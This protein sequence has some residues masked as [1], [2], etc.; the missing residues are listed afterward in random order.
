MQKQS[1]QVSSKE[2]DISQ[3]RKLERE[4]KWQKKQL[5]LLKVTIG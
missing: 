3:A 4:E 1:G 5:K 2:Q